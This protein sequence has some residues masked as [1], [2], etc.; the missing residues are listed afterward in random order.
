V[1]VLSKGKACTGESTRQKNVFNT[2]DDGESGDTD[3]PELQQFGESKRRMRR[4]GD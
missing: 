1:L 3:E 2:R 4:R